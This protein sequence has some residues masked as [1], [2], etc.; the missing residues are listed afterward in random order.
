M[1]NLLKGTV[2][3]SDSPWYASTTMAIIA[4]LIKKELYLNNWFYFLK[5]INL[6]FG[7]STKIACRFLLHIVSGNYYNPTFQLEKR[8]YLQHY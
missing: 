8:Q 7:F 5:F 4:C 6:N 1:S 3:S 2:I